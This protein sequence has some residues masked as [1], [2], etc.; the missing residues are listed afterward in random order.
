[1]VRE[2]PLRRHA[3][4]LA[5]SGLDGGKLI[6]NLRLKLASSLRTHVPLLTAELQGTVQESDEGSDLGLCGSGRLGAANRR[7]GLTEAGLK[8]T[9]GLRGHGRG[10]KNE[11]E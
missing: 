7:E 1:M 8:L 10:A 11:D 5:R 9:R 6:G 2:S 3:L 4:Q